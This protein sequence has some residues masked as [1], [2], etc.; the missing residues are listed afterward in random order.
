M[1]TKQAVPE[2]KV[3]T[4]HS[5]GDS[6]QDH[7]AGRLGGASLEVLKPETGTDRQGFRFRVKIRA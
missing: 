5:G 2:P 4:V 3:R 7:A 1:D 6:A